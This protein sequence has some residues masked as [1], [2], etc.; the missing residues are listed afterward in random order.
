MHV[1]FKVLGLDFFAKVDYHPGSPGRLTGHPDNR[2]PSDPATI[3]INELYARSEYSDRYFDDERG[4]DSAGFLLDCD[5]TRLIEDAAI[6]A[7]EKELK[8]G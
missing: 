4:F 6:L 8:N 5:I 3:E 7:I 2:E 1:K